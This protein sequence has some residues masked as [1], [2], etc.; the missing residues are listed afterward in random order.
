LAKEG[1]STPLALLPFGYAH[2]LRLTK[3]NIITSNTQYDSI[4]VIL[5]IIN[6]NSIFHNIFNHKA[7]VQK[8]LAFQEWIVGVV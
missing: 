8:G 3:I 2:T 4:S 5:K 6:N 1:A 7:L